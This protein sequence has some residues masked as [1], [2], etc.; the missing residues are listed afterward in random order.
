MP[1]TLSHA[2]AVLPLLRRS[3]RARG[4][5]VAPALVAGSFAPDLTYY[6]G[7]L[8]PGAT[9]FGGVT[10]SL[11]GVLT[12]DVLLSAV[13]VGAW[14]VLREPLAVLVPARWR[15]RVYGAARGRPGRG[16]PWWRRAFWFWVSAALG[17][18]THVVWDAFT[19]PGRWGVRLVPPLGETVAGYPL[20]FWVQ[21]GSSAL[22]L[23]IL[24]VAVVTAVRRAPEAVGVESAPRPAGAGRWTGAVFLGGCALAG[25]VHRC[26]RQ[27]ALTGWEYTLVDYAPAALF[28]AGAGLAAGLVARAAAVRIG[29]RVRRGRRRAGSPGAA[30]PA[31]AVPGAGTGGTT[32]DGAA[33]GG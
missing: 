29:R 7:S 27:H 19:H 30:R 15:R 21:Y 17:A 12:V 9:A 22:A 24:T 14:P 5:L 26:V 18:A 8:V 3:G 2:A 28:G 10:H 6:A 32:G 4:P 16:L 31:G 23:V 20:H 13:L 33:R 1:F 25:A 11:A